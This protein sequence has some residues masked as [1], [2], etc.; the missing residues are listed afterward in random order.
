MAKL[1]SP[2]SLCR[3]NYSMK[4]SVSILRGTLS[5]LPRYA[6]KLQFPHH[7]QICLKAVFFT[8]YVRQCCGVLSKKTKMILSSNLSSSFSV[9]EQDA[10][11]MLSSQ[12]WP[13][14]SLWREASKSMIWRHKEYMK[15]TDKYQ[16]LLFER[17]LSFVIP[18][19][20]PSLSIPA[21][22]HVI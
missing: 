12:P 5:F 4:C 6:R 19:L 20:L 7:C 8:M 17:P 15:K 11:P 16:S 18:P 13:L 22:L 14:T 2:F 9:L 21:I 3:E 1:S 10:G